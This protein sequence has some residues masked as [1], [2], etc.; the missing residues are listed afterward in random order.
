M[1]YILEALRKMDKQRKQ[2]STDGSWVE[3]LTAEPEEEKEKPH[4]PVRWLVAA[5]IFFGLAGIITGFVLYHGSQAPEK[6][7]APAVQAK[8]A[9]AKPERTVQAPSAPARSEEAQAV[10]KAPPR[11]RPKAESQAQ[12]LSEI[13]A[14]LVA[15]EESPE[16]KKPRAAP[17]AKEESQEVGKPPEAKVVSPAPALPGPGAPPRQDKVVDLT[18]R[19]RLSSTGEVNQKKYATLDRNDYSVGDEFMGMV[20]T[21]IERDRVHLKGKVDG[22]RYVIRFGYR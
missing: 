10:E 15:R 21:A 16:V 3:S 13:K 6:E 11:P 7:P 22:Q 12:T 5:S 17:V 8:K 9:P 1:S 4:R 2:D 19:Y 20:L 18:G 14:A